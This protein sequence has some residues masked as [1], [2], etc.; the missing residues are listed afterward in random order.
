MDAVT[1]DPL[2]EKYCKIARKLIDVELMMREDED[3]DDEE[4][5]AGDKKKTYTPA[6][7]KEL[8]LGLF[9]KYKA[10]LMLSQMHLEPGKKSEMSVK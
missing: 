3:D 1:T 5:K 6:Q 7:V 8:A 4:E 9:T 2:E 10:E